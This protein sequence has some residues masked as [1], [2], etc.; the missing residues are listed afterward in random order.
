MAKTE[1]YQ[2]VAL[3][4]ELSLTVRAKYNTVELAEILKR[5]IRCAF[6]NN[7]KEVLSA[8]FKEQNAILNEGEWNKLY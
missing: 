1:T 7:D 5:G 4:L 8:Q 2:Q 3:K 6:P